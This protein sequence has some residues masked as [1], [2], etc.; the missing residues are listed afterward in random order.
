[1]NL[2][3]SSQINMHLWYLFFARDNKNIKIEK[4]EE[5]K[6]TPVKPITESYIEDSLKRDYKESREPIG[7][8]FDIYI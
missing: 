4:Q 7:R 3:K 1:M 5:R 6:I 2:E 8:H